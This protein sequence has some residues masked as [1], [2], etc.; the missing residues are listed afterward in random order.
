[1]ADH[2]VKRKFGWPVDGA[3]VAADWRAR[4]YSCDLFVDPPVVNGTTSSTLE[5]NW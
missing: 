5:T 3:A 2:V 1:M 4:G